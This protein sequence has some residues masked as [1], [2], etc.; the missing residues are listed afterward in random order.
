MLPDMTYT[1]RVR[2]TVSNRPPQDVTAAE[3]SV[4]ATGSFRTG[5]LSGDTVGLAAPQDR[6][7]VSSLTPTLTWTNNNKQAF[8]YELQVSK[9]AA[10][11][12]N[13]FLYL[14]ADTWRREHT[15]Q[16][17]RH[18][19]EISLGARHHLPLA[20]A[21]PH[22]GRRRRAALVQDLDVPYAVGQGTL[23]RK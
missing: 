12:P 1:W 22:P 17:L 18:P 10:F 8:Y 15:G 9:D 19:P 2:T 23:L 6:G 4:W 13:A 11:G 14:G 3:W 7:T 21:S 5:V 16:Q 20:G